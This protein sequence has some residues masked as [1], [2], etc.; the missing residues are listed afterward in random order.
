MTGS[1]NTQTFIKYLSLFLEKILS[2]MFH[3]ISEQFLPSIKLDI[4]AGPI[5]LVI[6]L[7]LH[8]MIF[9]SESCGLQKPKAKSVI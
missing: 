9:F 8:L 5:V 1:L 6:L 3:F 2:L 4:V 7:W